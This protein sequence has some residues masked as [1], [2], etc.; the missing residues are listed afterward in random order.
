MNAVKEKAF[1]KIN[2]Y[3]DVV[4][5]RDDGFHDI[6]SVMHAVSLCDNITVSVADARETKIFMTLVGNKFL[7]CD[8]KNLAVR[9]ARLFLESLG[10]CAEVKISLEKNIP[11]GAG[12][13]GGSADAAA[14]LRALNKL[15]KRPFTDKALSKIADSLGSDVPFCLFGKTALCEGRG[16]IMTPIDAKLHLDAVVAVADEYVSTP[17]AYA[18]LDKIFSSFDGSVPTCEGDKLEKMLCGIKD[19]AISADSYFNI[20][21][22]AVLPMKPGAAAIKEKLTMLGAS[23]AQMSGSGPSVFG[24][25]PSADDASRAAEELSCMGYKAFCVSSV[26]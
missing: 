3:L 22:A 4:A 26:L 18:E 14:V 12:L 17:M 20:F 11:V 19:G 16:E 2:L 5:L 10:K 8:D 6:K 21:E 1:A 9:A 24:V 23:V 25:F 7:P 13:A 15:Y